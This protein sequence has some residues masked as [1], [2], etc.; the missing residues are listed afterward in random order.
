[1]SH[2]FTKIDIHGIFSTKNREGLISPKLEPLLYKK[3]REI[4]TRDLNCI[5]HTING[6]DDHIHVLFA[7]N[8]SVSVSD[9]F[10][11]IKGSSSHF[12]NQ[13]DII[14]RKFAWQT[15]YAAFSV[16]PS[17]FQ[18]AF[19]YIEN[20]KQHHKTKTFNQELAA[21]CKSHGVEWQE[22]NP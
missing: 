11:S 6:I 8:P 15:G 3:I 19:K 16:S 7:L 5:L 20:Q 12:V 22:E 1:M 2:S 10:K 9:V 4:F 13:E 18:K 17:Q 21:L 14:A